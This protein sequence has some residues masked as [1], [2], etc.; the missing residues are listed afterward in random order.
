MF[1]SVKDVQ[2]LDGIWNKECPIMKWGSAV[3]HLKFFWNVGIL[4]RLDAPYNTRRT[5]I[6][7]P[8]PEQTRMPVLRYGR[9]LISDSRLSMSLGET[10]SAVPSSWAKMETRYSSRLQRRM[11]SFLNAAKDFLRVMID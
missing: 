11:S 9:A 1:Q 7:P 6:L 2:Y 4:V 5:R 10:G 3:A 8:F